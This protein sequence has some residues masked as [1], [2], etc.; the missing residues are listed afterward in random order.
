MEGAGPVGSKPDCRLPQPAVSAA[1]LRFSP[2]RPWAG[3]Q[4]L[5]VSIP[6]A[7]CKASCRSSVTCIE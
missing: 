2:G 7:C 5:F 1:C 6:S 3:Q 4:H